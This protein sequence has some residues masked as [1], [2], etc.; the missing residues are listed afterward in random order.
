[1]SAETLMW[2]TAC[3][4]PVEHAVTALDLAAGCG[5]DSDGDLLALCGH[6]FLTAPL[7]ADPGARCPW[8]ARFARARAT[9]HRVEERLARSDRADWITA[10]LARLPIARWRS[11]TEADAGEKS[12]TRSRRSAAVRAS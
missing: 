8:C 6:R 4:E 10:L 5:S 12:A 9:L 3:G 11:N 7:V 2:V 1:M